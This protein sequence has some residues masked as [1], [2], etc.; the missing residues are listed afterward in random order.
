MAAKERVIWSSEINLEDWKDYLEDQHPNVTDEDEQL[1]LCQEINSY[2]LGDERTNLDIPLEGRVL[3]IASMGLWNGRRSG[4]KIL[5]RNVNEIFMR[6][7]CDETKWFSDGYNVRFEGIHHDGS[8]YVEFRE[9]REDKDIEKLLE[10][11]WNNQKVSR[12]MIRRH[13]RSLLPHV[14]K[15]YGW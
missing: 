3:A 1:R 13:T 11:I 10:L 7:E 14:K 15:I 6:T 2:Y 12:E 8:N 9:I 5:G 4:Y